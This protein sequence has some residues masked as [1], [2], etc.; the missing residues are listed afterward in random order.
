MV[1]KLG[2]DASPVEEVRGEKGALVAV[3]LVMAACSSG[4]ASSSGA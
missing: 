4:T 3:L 1:R 2:D